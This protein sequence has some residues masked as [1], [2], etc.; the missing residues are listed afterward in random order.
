M[1]TKRR[2]RKTQT[3]SGI[4]LK[5]LFFIFILL[6]GA[7]WM[8]A[9]EERGAEKVAVSS[10]VGSLWQEKMVAKKKAQ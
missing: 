3:G 7:L 8:V 10:E 4:S 5:A 2:K 9:P 6:A 1:A